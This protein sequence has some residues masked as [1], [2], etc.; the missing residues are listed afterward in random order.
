VFN[1]LPNRLHDLGN[2][3]KS[4]IIKDV[5]FK[6]TQILDIMLWKWFSVNSS[7]LT[8]DLEEDEL[9]K[10]SPTKARR[11]NF[12]IQSQGAPIGMEES[13]NLMHLMGETGHPQ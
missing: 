1:N 13:S 2:S 11:R 4:D 12:N 8:P 9:E 6:G 3:H 7:F 5:E 10:N